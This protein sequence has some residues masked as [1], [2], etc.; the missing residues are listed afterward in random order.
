MKKSRTIACALTGALLTLSVVGCQEAPSST[1]SEEILLP[2]A[3]YRVHIKSPELKEGET[4]SKQE[5]KTR[6]EATLQ[7]IRTFSAIMEETDGWQEAHKVVQRE[8]AASSESF[9][10][11]REQTSALYMLRFKLLAGESS[12]EKLEAISYY[13]SLLVA[14]GSPEGDV[15]LK[16]LRKLEGHWTNEKIVAT[17]SQAAEATEAFLSKRFDCTDC[18]S[19]ATVAALHKRAGAA[20][21]EDVFL[22]QAIG[23]LSQLREMSQQ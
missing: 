5:R 15:I 19:K 21:Q 1:A 4:L 11:S 20:G 6:A 22:S 10:Y 9:R 23:V 17:A 16:S 8:L 13:T 7:A 18:A 12:P 2:S 3:D 14:N